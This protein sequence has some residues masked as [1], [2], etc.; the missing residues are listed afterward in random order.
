MSEENSLN[1]IPEKIL[2][3][4]GRKPKNKLQNIVS[5]VEEHIDSEKEVI[6][7]YLPITLD[8]MEEKN[9]KFD[10]GSSAIFMKP[11]TFIDKNEPDLNYDKLLKDKN[12]IIAINNTNNNSNGIYINKI[13][14][15]QIELDVNTKCWWCKNCFTTPNIV[16]PEHYFNGT[17]YCIGNFCSYNC[18]KAYNIDMNDSNIW[19]RES[20]INLMY[21]MTFTKFKLIE[22]SPSWLILKEFGGF[23]SITEFRKNLETNTAEYILLYPPLISRQ[24][25]IEESYKKQDN[26][27]GSLNKLDKL[28]YPVTDYSLSRTKPVETTQLN[29]EKTMGLKRRTK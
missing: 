23:M 3:K 9:E 4:R 22:P 8:D 14:I 7:A 29:L 24:M 20:L 18:C 13:N 2:K 26:T 10:I 5:V 28:F 19:K 17:F 11:D 16:L 15:Y 12:E 6:I 1:T 25:Q 21:Q 27:T